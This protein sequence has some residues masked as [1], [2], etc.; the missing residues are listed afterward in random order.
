M[1]P[2]TVTRCPSNRPAFVST[3]LGEVT[4]GCPAAAQAN[5]ATRRTPSETRNTLSTAQS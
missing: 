2:L 4:P 1:L 3:S 5:A